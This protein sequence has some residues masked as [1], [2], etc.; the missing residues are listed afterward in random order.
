MFNRGG[1]QRTLEAP[2]GFQIKGHPQE[3][4]KKIERHFKYCKTCMEIRGDEKVSPPEFNKIAGKMNGWNGVTTNNKRPTQMITT[5]L[6]DGERFDVLVEASNLKDAIDDVKL[7]ASM[8]DV[9][10]FGEPAIKTKK[11]VKKNKK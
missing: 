5:A 8:V 7:M 9:E 4:N 11:K 2:C 6:I 3:V 1:Q 10:D